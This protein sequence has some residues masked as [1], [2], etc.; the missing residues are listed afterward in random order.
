MEKEDFDRFSA[1]THR[2]FL[3]ERQI[4]EDTYLLIE[5]D[6]IVHFVVVL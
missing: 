1:N 3:V 4:E 5:S 6:D 2:H